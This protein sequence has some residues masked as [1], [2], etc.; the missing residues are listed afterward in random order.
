MQKRNI[1]HIE[2]GELSKKYENAYYGPHCEMC[3]SLK[4]VKLN[5]KPC[6]TYLHLFSTLLWGEV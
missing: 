5:T 6:G 4:N 1:S 2:C 3:E